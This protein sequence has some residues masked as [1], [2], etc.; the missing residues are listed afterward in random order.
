[1]RLGLVV[2]LVAAVVAGCLGAPDATPETSAD[3]DL[4][5][6]DDDTRAYTYYFVAGRRMTRE[7]PTGPPTRVEAIPWV[8]GFA[9]EDLPP[10]VGPAPDRP[11][12]VEGNATVTLYYTVEK[13][14]TPVIPNTEGQ[15]Y[16]FVP[17]F[18]SGATYGGS[19][20]HYGPPVLVPGEVYQ[21]TIDVP[22]PDAGF[23]LTP[24]EPVQVLIAT[25]MNTQ[26]ATPVEFLVGSPETPSHVQF[27]AT[28]VAPIDTGST[29][30][31]STRGTVAA[32]GG[33][34]LPAP[35]R[36]GA[37]YAEHDLEV[38][39]EVDRLD[40]RL[41]HDEPPEAKFDIDMTVLGPD[42]D[43]VAAGSTPYQS[44]TAVL[45]PETLAE[46]GSGTY[47]VRVDVYSGALVRYE[48]EATGLG[49]DVSWAE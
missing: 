40:L 45:W 10:W 18:G 11:L 36:N 39:S 28:P 6:E 49:G 43:E 32:N 20:G 46:H 42:G 30:E 29:S 33:L 24:D 26:D 13:P 31:T 47:T 9:N 2:L 16:H 5:A 37:T 25:L 1:M 48:V 22:L 17:W 4:A 23:R 19:G 21:A 27:E 14:V 15:A 38:S 3:P 41:T 12:L 44:E 7:A 8:N 35:E 34:F